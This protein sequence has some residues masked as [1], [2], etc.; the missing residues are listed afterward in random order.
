MAVKTLAPEPV[1]TLA[2]ASAQLKEPVATIAKYCR[3]G[4]IAAYKTGSGGRTSK[5]MIPMSALAKYQQNR[6]NDRH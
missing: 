5:W 3:T 4:K 1:A 2:E 6:L